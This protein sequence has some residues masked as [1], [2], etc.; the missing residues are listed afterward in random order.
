MKPQE[1]THFHLFGGSG[2]GAAG[3]KAGDALNAYSRACLDAGLPF[4]GADD[5]RVLLLENM[6]EYQMY[7]RSVYDK[8][9]TSA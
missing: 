3:F 6:V 5:G 2:S 1:V 9:G 7:L 8:E 4:K